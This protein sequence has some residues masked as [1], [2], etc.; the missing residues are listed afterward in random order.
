MNAKATWHWST[1]VITAFAILAG[2][3]IIMCAILGPGPAYDDLVGYQPLPAFIVV[4]GLGTLALLY[5]AQKVAA[6]TIGSRAIW[7][8][9]IAIFTVAFGAEVYASLPL[10]G[11]FLGGC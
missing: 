7:V 5:A 10:L 6:E 4:G 3:P 2:I 9:C 11:C 8:S 1:P